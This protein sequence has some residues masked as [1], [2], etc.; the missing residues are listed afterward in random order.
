M[1]ISNMYSMEL[2]STLVEKEHY[3][4]DKKLNSKENRSI[5]NNQ[6]DVLIKFKLIGKLNSSITMLETWHVKADKV[7]KFKNIIE[8]NN[9]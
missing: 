4:I 3:Q 7:P 5:H 2:F 9:D 1:H 6:I 8:S